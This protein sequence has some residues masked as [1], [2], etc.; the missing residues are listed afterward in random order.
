MLFKQRCICLL[1]PFLPQPYAS[2]YSLLCSELARD[3]SLHSKQETA[4]GA[5]HHRMHLR[6][7]W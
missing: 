3:S 6:T 4:D 2:V 5:A 1:P 7:S